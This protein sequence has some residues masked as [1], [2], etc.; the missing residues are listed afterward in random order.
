VGRLLSSGFKEKPEEGKP[1]TGNEF[2][3]RS[4]LAF[5]HRVPEIRSQS[6]V[7]KEKPDSRQVCYDLRALAMEISQEI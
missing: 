4:L 2:P 5:G 6:P 1:V 3:G 7:C